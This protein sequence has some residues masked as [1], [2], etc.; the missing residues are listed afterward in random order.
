MNKEDRDFIIDA[1]SSRPQKNDI[2]DHLSKIGVT[3]CSAGIIYL[4][5]VVVNV[6]QDVALIKHSQ[7]AIKEDVSAISTF[8]EKPRFT[9][10]DY[11]RYEAKQ[12]DLLLK[13]GDE[14]AIRRTWIE[15][16]DDR[17]NEFERTFDDIRRDIEDIRRDI[18]DVQED[19]GDKIK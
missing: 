17:F 19:M 9:K 8:T 11:D 4:A 10:D 6:Q 15:A 2:Y 13:I 3:I 18:Q 16:S 7:A 14:L 1:I 12:N 5:G